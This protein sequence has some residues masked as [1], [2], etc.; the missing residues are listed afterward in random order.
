MRKFRAVVRR[1]YVQRVRSK[2]F[3]I[4]T[5]GAP[6]MFALF[7]VVPMLMAGIRTGGPFRLAVV[8]E[9]GRMYERMRESLTRGRDDVSDEEEEAK[10]EVSPGGQDNRKRMEQAAKASEPGY[11]VEQVAAADGRTSQE[12]M[13]QLDA[14]VKK[15]EIDAYL[16]LPKDTLEGGEA[17][18]FARNVADQ[19][20]RGHVRD[21]LT[22]AVRDARL[23]ERGIKPEVMRA[24]NQPVKMKSE[25]AGG[26]GEGE[27]KGEG[28]FL[29]FGV[30]FVIYLTI[31]LYGQVVLG[32]VVEEKETRIAE[33][34]FSSIRSFT[35][36]MGKL[37]GVSLVALTQFA[38]W[39]AAIAAFSL[40]GAAAL[41]SR[42]V[43]ININLH[44]PFSVFAY[45]V[46]FFLLGYFI[47]STI[48]A[49]VGS[50]VTTSQEGGQ[51]AMPV[52]LLLILGFYM[53]FPVIR[54]PNSSFAFWVSLIPFFSPITMLIRIVAQTPP[55]WQIALSLGIGFATVALLLWLAS[56]VYR[57]GMLMYG[58]RAT[59]P[60]VL[61]WIR[62]P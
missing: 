43:P 28:F 58:K 62:Q 12:L 5:L 53:A 36:L 16:I 1:E 42:G 38:I 54:A 39:G 9:T 27:D 29:V 35:L 2:M 10:P 40:Y 25:K 20:T 48:Y 3:L 26:G 7:T 23:D 52:I 56:R 59:I 57:V 24:V 46:L 22:K 41:A 19:F 15:E 18:Y 17:Q 30:G 6:L 37:V 13:R 45:T 14:R 31:L 50:M 55:F 32:A 49:L 8:D 47:Y 4:V 34:L 11:A 51:L 33:I 44:I 61:K 60:E 21:S